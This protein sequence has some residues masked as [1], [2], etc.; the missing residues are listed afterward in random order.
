LS[1]VV[2]RDMAVDLGTANTVV[3]VRGQGIVLDEPSIVAINTRNQQLLAVGA[4]AKRMLGR[5]PAHIQAIRPLKDGVIADFDICEKMLRYFIQRVHQ[6]R[7]AKP[8][9]VICIPSGITGVERRAVQE[10]AEFAGARK[11]A[12]VIE[13][14]MAAAI[15]AGLPVHEPAGNMIVDIGGGTTEVAVISLGGIVA[16][17][18]IRIAGDELD[19]AIITFVKR[20]FS[21]A[22]GERTAEEIKVALASAY[23]LEEELIAEIRGRDLVSGL[24]KTVEIST[25]DI[26]EAIEEPVAAI[27]DAVKVTLDKTPPELAADIMSAGIVVTGGGA[28]LHGLGQRLEAETGMPIRIADDPLSSVAVGSGQCLEEFPALKQVLI[29]S[30]NP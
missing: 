27:V 7:W 17:E 13:E 22:L 12:L 15:G 21:L 18:S 30:S 20:E 2:G 4:E 14:P 24:P 9:M 26:R 3:Y 28:L 23:P 11:P 5:T 19:D 1:S 16:S 10:A 25:A 6:R 29:S 8:R